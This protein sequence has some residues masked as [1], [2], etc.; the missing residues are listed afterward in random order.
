MIRVLI[1]PLRAQATD[2]RDLEAAAVAQQQRRCA[3]VDI[4]QLDLRNPQKS[5]AA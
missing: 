1:F 3:D 5:T 4:L 2:L